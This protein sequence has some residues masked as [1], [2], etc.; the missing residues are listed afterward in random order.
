MEGVAADLSF[1]SAVYL[2]AS[3]VDVPN[4]VEDASVAIVSVLGT[5]GGSEVVVSGTA[6]DTSVVVLSVP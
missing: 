4:T 2:C 3:V 5:D 6:V 1:W